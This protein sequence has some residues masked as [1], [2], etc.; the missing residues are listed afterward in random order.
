M[1]YRA[2]GL[3]K[4]LDFSKHKA[5]GITDRCIVSVKVAYQ[6]CPYFQRFLVSSINILY[7]A[8]SKVLTQYCQKIPLARNPPRH[9]FHCGCVSFWFCLQASWL[10]PLMGSDHAG[11]YLGHPMAILVL[12]EHH[13]STM[14]LLCLA[15][16]PL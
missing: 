12:I 7:A 11:S 10:K 15:F 3:Q 1:R 14:P 4:E 2:L 6:N 5:A 16:T 8:V 13:L 9:I